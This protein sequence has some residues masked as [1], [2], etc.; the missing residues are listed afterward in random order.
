MTSA[1]GAWALR[2]CDCVKLKLSTEDAMDEAILAGLGYKQTLR[3]G[4]SFWAR[5]AARSLFRLVKPSH[6]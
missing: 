2:D 5:Q 6:F 1:E 3:R 4:M